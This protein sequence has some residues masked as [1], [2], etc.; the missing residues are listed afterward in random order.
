MKSVYN[1]LSHKEKYQLFS[2]RNNEKFDHFRS[3]YS[4]E[5]ENDLKFYQREMRGYDVIKNFIL[6]NGGQIHTPLVNLDWNI[7]D[8]KIG[9]DLIGFLNKYKI[10]DVIIENNTF[11]YRGSY[12]WVD[13]QWFY[14][15]KNPG[16]RFVSVNIV[17]D[18]IDT[19]IT[20]NRIE[21]IEKSFWGDKLFI[22]EVDLYPFIDNIINHK[23]LKS[24]EKDEEPIDKSQYDSR[25][26]KKEFENRPINF[27]E[28]I[29][30]GEFEDYVL[31]IDE[32]QL[33][34]DFYHTLDK[35]IA[36]EHT[37]YL[38]EIDFAK[39][40]K[41]KEKKITQQKIQKLNFKE[42]D[43]N[44][45]GQ[46]DILEGE[47]VL[48]D[49]VNKFEKTIIEFDYELIK[50]LVKLNDF[51]NSKR[52]NLKKIFEIFQMI[53]TQD[54]LVEIL[55]IF[56][57][58]INNYNLLTTHSI[59]MVV[60]LSEKQMTTYYE[61]HTFF[62]KLN[63]F[64]SKWERS[65]YEKLALIDLRLE[66]LSSSIKEVIFSIQSMEKNISESLDNLSYQTRS[67]FSELQ[68]KVTEELKSIR[69]GVGL[70][71]LLTGIQ[72]YQLYN[73][74]KNTNSASSG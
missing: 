48:I 62:D 23:V 2:T 21:R 9:S 22:E 58:S 73:I 65:V 44:K 47:N 16:I 18:L 5:N 61:L 24:Y 55:E 7:L 34:K 13:E 71:N 11:E 12:D 19:K 66:N 38:Q 67:S 45:D 43:K 57:N 4:I 32:I 27:W 60:S 54:S 39:T 35:Y 63:V 6:A 8:L 72:T 70:N 40:Q 3:L 50:D 42:F 46:L 74:N 30:K 53:E 64:D 14:N 29:E 26:V 59:N 49:L 51:L 31:N 69:T 1:Q 28:F 25:K 17:D 41:K 20:V 10:E 56:R 36:E 37:K 68:G 15:G 52:E 33:L